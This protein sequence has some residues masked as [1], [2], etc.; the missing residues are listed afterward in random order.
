MKRALLVLPVL[1]LLIGLLLFLLRPSQN[2]PGPNRA[3]AVGADVALSPA[4]ADHEHAP[5]AAPKPLDPSLTGAV[6]FFVTAQGQPLKDAKITAQKDGTPDFMRFTTEADGTQ[7]LRGMPAVEFS[8]CIEHPDFIPQTAELR[9][10]PSK[11]S[12]LRIDLKRGGRIYGT[13][14]DQATGRPV[15]Q[16]KV[17]LLAQFEGNAR[18]R[19]LPATTVFTDEKGQ[20]QIKAIPPTLVGMRFRHNRYEPL[21]RMDLLFKGPT[22]EYRIDVALTMGQSIRGRVLDEQGKPIPGA[23]VMASNLE[24]AMTG[25]SAEDGTFDIGGLYHKTANF[26][27]DKKGYGKVILRNLPVDGPP[28]ELRLPKAG[29]LIGKVIADAALPEFQIV[30][31][32][33][34]DE[35]KQVIQ[36]ESRQFQKSPGNVFNLEDIAP[37]AYW[38]EIQVEGYEAV[39]RPQVQIIGGQI[40]EGVSITLRKKD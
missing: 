35:L 20:Y 33:F 37:G 14:T 23:H 15:P 19:P 28:V 27:A 40:T 29:S 36:V 6:K 38:V 22:D 7:L 25:Y 16:T 34:D 8:F 21:D 2:G 17:F 26:Q 39:D 1:A 31:S 5:P 4:H 30:L 3:E 32:R 24:S 18:P 12:E 11:T 10:E 9:V 13:V